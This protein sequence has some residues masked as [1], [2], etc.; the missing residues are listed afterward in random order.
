LVDVT[1]DVEARGCHLRWP[2]AGPSGIRRFWTGAAN[3]SPHLAIVAAVLGAACGGAGHASKV[4]PANAA[5]AGMSIAIYDRDGLDAYGVVDDRRW[6]DVTGGALE[7]DRVDPRADLPS[8]VIEPM[9]GGALEIGTCL[10]DRIPTAPVTA[11]D[12]ARVVSAPASSPTVATAAPPAATPARPAF[13]PVL[14]CTA[15]GAPGRYLVRVLYVVPELGYRV[16]H[17]VTV[18]AQDRA[19]VVSRFAIVTP[20]WQV[21]AEL[22]LFDGAPGGERPPRELA[23]GAAVFDGGIAVIAVPRR[24][25]TARLRWI[26]DGAVIG[27]GSDDPSPRD[28][29]WGQ[30]SQPAVWVWLEL[31]APALAPGPVRAHIELAGEATRDIDVPAAGRRTTTA[32]VR[33]PL[34]IDDQLRGRRERR[35]DARNDAVLTDRFQLSIANLGEPTRDV[36]IEEQLRPARHRTVAGTWPSEPTIIDNRLR[37]KLTVRGGKIERGGFDVAYER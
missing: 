25:V 13:A 22:A 19:A 5:G 15:R 11:P 7:I 12:S 24:V 8:L 31:D 17:D 10:R 1:V 4:A 3:G 34:W 28:P 2:L 36:W 9:A 14:H 26:Y 35:S 32:G 37:M 21:R 30:K 29:Q 6:I 20:A 18:T 27:H 16:Q 33:L 23:R